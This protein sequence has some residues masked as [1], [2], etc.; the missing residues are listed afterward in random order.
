MA[1][2]ESERRADRNPIDP[3]THPLRRRILRY[4]HRCAEPKGLREVAAALD[5]EIPQTN[6]HLNSLASFKTI[7]KAGLASK[8][9]SVRYESAVSENPEVLALLEARQDE[10]EG[11][12]AA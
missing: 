2:P 12:V 9:D 3:L 8:A 11:R 1:T 10:D 4:L 7:R 5:A 6:Y